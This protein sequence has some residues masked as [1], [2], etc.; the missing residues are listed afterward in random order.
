[1]SV[2]TLETDYLVIGSDAAG[3]AFTDTLVTE[4][5]AQV[6]IGLSRQGGITHACRK[7][8]LAAAAPLTPRGLG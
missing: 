2:R 3:M 7:Y 1:M 8:T 6:V 4:S 5:D